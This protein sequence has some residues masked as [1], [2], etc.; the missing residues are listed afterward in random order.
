MPTH[1]SRSA[2]LAGALLSFAGVA[3]ILPGCQSYQ[4][5]PLDLPAHGDAWRQR[6]AGDEPV[7]AFARRLAQA[8]Q[9]TAFDP[10][11]GLELAEAELV[12]LVFNP[13]LRLARLRAGVALAT[14]EHAG[15]WEDPQFG[16]DVLTVT[17]S[18]ANPWQVTPGLAFTIPISGRLGAEK[19]R[20]DAELSAELARVAELE[21]ATRT[22]V[23]QAWLRWSAVRLKDEQAAALLGSI[24]ALVDSTASLADAGE[25][26]RTE[27]ALFVIERA[28]LRQARLRSRREAVALEH[29]LRGLLGLSPGAPFEL[30]PSL[31]LDAD[32]DGLTA[33]A[34]AERSPTLG[35]LREEYE[36]AEQTLRREVREQYPDLTIGPLAEFDRG[37]TLLGLSL[38]LPI[39]ILNANKQGIAEA[40][41]Q[42]ELARAE[43]ETT[44]ERLAGSLAAQ[45]EYLF[46]AAE[47]R[48][49]I[50]T[51]LIPIV[52]RH[53]ADARALL[54]LGEDGG[55][56][57]LESL[58]RSA[59]AR[60][61]LID[62]R[63]D[64]SLA[65][66]EL[67]GLVGPPPD[68]PHQSEPATPTPHTNGPT[69]TTDEV[70]P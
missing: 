46:A 48:R 54:E 2:G 41:A 6:T 10:A 29:E 68:P 11:D 24:D 3:A 58:S 57:V 20:A 9:P 62:A 7:R 35:R 64:E 67:V 52:D 36:V 47:H 42:R 27:A 69:P 55:L 37:D 34:L 49:A 43:F 61:A 59:E 70:T 26:P 33:E 60:L 51:E 12:A 1:P 44:Y 25:M 31:V 16:L 53:M 4:P 39:P 23:R 22:R 63:L 40:H 21:W 45:T 19:D 65:L 5:R 50:E 8:G 14:A 18:A 15:L 13:D 28:S 56:V 30:T 32:P 38:S 66:A 17:E